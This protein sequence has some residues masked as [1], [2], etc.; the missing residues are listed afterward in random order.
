MA[1]SV[2]P[3]G[4]N[5]YETS[6]PADE[7]LVGTLNGIASLK[8]TGGTWQEARRLLEGKHAESIAIEPTRGIIFAG[9]HDGGGLWASEDGGNNWER[10]DAGIT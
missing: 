3:N 8:R 7:V 10:R 1:V 9:T 2:S 6:A 5:L 4:K